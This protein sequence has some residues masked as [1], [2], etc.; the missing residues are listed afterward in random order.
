M[1]S[2]MMCTYN[3]TSILNASINSS[4]SQNYDDLELI[5]WDNSDKS[6]QP[7]KLIQN[8][9]EAAP[10][11]HGYKSN[12]NYGWPKGASSCMKEEVNV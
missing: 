4:F 5:I 8:A 1:F 7:W 10:R 2:F 12:K 3:D 9:M 11:I 6:E